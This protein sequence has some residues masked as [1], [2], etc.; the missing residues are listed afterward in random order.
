MIKTLTK[1]WHNARLDTKVLIIIFVFG[2]LFEIVIFFRFP[3]FAWMEGLLNT[4][5]TSKGLHFYRDFMAY[6]APV[7]RLSA[8]PLHWVFGLKQWPTVF[9]QLFRAEVTFFLVFYASLKFCKSWTRIVPLIFYLAWDVIV[10]Q[11][12]FSPNGFLELLIFIS[13]INWLDWYK[14]PKKKNAFI[15]GLCGGLAVFSAQIILPFFV[16]MFSTLAFVSL[17]EKRS[18]VSLKSFSIGFSIPAVFTLSWAISQGIFNDFYFWTVKYLL[19]YYPK[20]DL[21]RAVDNKFIFFSLHAPLLL[22]LFPIIRSLREKKYETFWKY[23]LLSSMLIILPISYW[24]AIFHV[25]RF[26]ISLAVFA[27]FF[28]LLLEE[29]KKEKGKIK[30]FEALIIVLI[31]CLNIYSFWKYGAPRYQRYLL[32]PREKRIMTMF[33]PDDPA[34]HIAAWVRDNT[35]EDAKLFII[36]DPAL[37]LETRRLPVNSRASLN[38]PFLY[39]PLA[40]LE[41]NLEKNPPGYWIVDERIWERFHDFGYDTATDMFKRILKDKK[42]VFRQEYVV[43]IK[44]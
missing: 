14:K 17:K 41:K 10:T 22:T 39:E 23:S 16:V 34:Y 43:V 38:L 29:F 28:G 35:P 40:D 24:F 4:W 27:I 2:V 37:Y 15:M 1:K 20:S 44:N 25:I 33:Y 21:G 42:V 26:Q 19:F 32:G 6:Y 30:T 31:V 18:F 3:R 11:N 9:L 13:I 36:A 7:L 8:L 12:Q 5:Y